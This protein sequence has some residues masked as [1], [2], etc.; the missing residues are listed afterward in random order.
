[1]EITINEKAVKYLKK[2]K[3]LSVVI[4]GIPNETSAGCSCGGNAKKY[5]IPSIQ[6][7]FTNKERKQYRE[8][9]CNDYKIL[10]SNNIDVE[11]D[12][13]III[14]TEKVFFSEKLIVSG[15]KIKME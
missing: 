2:H 12:D 6:M 4:Y 10:I 11:K 3:P 1:M 5:Y 7:E 13:K 8:F 14:D 15:I 9:Y